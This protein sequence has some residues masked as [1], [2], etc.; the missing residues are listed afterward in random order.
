[1]N[2]PKST[3]MHPKLI[4]G[5]VWVPDAVYGGYRLL[6]EIDPKYMETLL[7]IDSQRFVELL[8]WVYNRE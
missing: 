8:D 4:D 1:M 5:K 7:W 3:N 2:N 6:P